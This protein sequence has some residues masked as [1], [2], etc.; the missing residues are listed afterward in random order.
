M[1]REGE[2]GVLTLLPH[3][4][5]GDIQYSCRRHKMTLAAKKKV[6]F[7][8]C[9]GNYYSRI[10]PESQPS[11]HK[12]L[13]SKCHPP[14]MLKGEGYIVKP[15]DDAQTR[16]VAAKAEGGRI[17]IHKLSEATLE[18]ICLAASPDPG[19]EG[20]SDPGMEPPP[21]KRQAVVLDCE[22]VGLRR[23]PRK[24][25]DR[26][27]EGVVE[28]CAVD[29]LTGEELVR[30]LVRPRRPVTD[31]RTALTGL[32]ASSLARAEAK[33]IKGKPT[34][35][36]GSAAARAALLRHVGPD[37]VIVG[38]AVRFDLAALGIA[39]ARI[40]DA[41]LLACE[42]VFRKGKGDGGDG[43]GDAPDVR[44]GAA[45]KSIGVGELLPEEDGNTNN[46]N[47]GS[48]N[49]SIEKKIKEKY[50]KFPR[51]W[52]LDTLCR[53]LLSIRIRRV[54]KNE[55]QKSKTVK[56]MEKMK[57]GESV[58]NIMEDV[59][60]V[61]EVVLCCLQRPEKLDAWAATERVIHEKWFRKEQEKIEKI[62]RG[63]KKQ[64]EKKKAHEKKMKERREEKKKLKKKSKEGDQ[65]NS[66]ATTRL[67]YSAPASGTVDLLNT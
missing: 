47:S 19:P 51:Q 2:G 24:P 50:K 61:R 44:V 18:S 22:M 40:V 54:G 11:V 3:E 45:D 20:L 17:D 46:N 10:P 12:L 64:E 15:A 41:A 62:K 53:D 39:H 8:E 67:P 42:A 55:G 1:G 6:R 27:T 34:P 9:R 33:G 13:L 56:K 5:K 57:K 52:G 58:H 14:D 36:R 35:L 59:L 43:G 32:T 21:P 63:L 30:S 66:T 7:I 16:A 23:G 49:V 48:G 37:T 28:I 29:F 60:A 38:Q 31:W 26:Q 25:G 4:R 65:I